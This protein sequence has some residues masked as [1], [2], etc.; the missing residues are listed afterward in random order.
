MKKAG[1]YYIPKTNGIWVVEKVDY[2]EDVFRP[3]F[4]IVNVISFKG[5]HYK[6]LIEKKQFKE[7][8]RLGIL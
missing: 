1:V 2:Y 5:Y 4:S 3:P 8:K 6:V 7:F